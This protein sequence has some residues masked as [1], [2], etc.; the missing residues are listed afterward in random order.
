[1]RVTSKTAIIVNVFIVFLGMTIFWL[2]IY[3]TKE[4]YRVK[5]TF[6][7]T[8]GTIYNIIIE[9]DYGSDVLTTMEYP[10]IEFA[11]PNGEKTKFTA[12]YSR[13]NVKYKTGDQIE[14]Y[15]NPQKPSEARIADYRALIIPGIITIFIGVVFIIF[16]GQYVIRYFSRKKIILE[17]K[18]TG[19]KIQAPFIEAKKD[20]DS[21]IM[22]KNP[23]IVR[24]QMEDGSSLFSERIWNFDPESLKTGQMIDV[25]FDPKDKSNYYIDL[26]PYTK[27]K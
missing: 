19:I 18:T 4:S 25:Y 12:D 2:G 6:S 22:N 15:Y 23:F 3:I 17:L 8:T 16:A 27:L 13:E 20:Y 24:V 10:Q 7:K 21:A 5:D 26:D 1:M 9:K 14:I 11:L